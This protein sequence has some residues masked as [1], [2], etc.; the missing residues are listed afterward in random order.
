MLRENVLFEAKIMVKAK[1]KRASLVP[2]LWYLLNWIIKDFQVNNTNKFIA[3]KKYLFF[4]LDVVSLWWSLKVCPRSAKTFA[5]MNFSFCVQQ[6]R[7]KLFYNAFNFNLRLTR[8]VSGE[9]FIPMAFTGNKQI[10]G[11]IF[12]FP[13]KNLINS[14]ARWRRK[15]TNRKFFD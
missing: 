11:K 9:N 6:K 8:E 2:W 10:T 15:G 14:R 12:P 1:R 13:V 3:A 5:G 4:Q 7:R